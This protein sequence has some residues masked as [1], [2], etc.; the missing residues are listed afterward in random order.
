MAIHEIFIISSQL[1][2][3]FLVSQNIVRQPMDVDGRPIDGRSMAR[4]INRQVAALFQIENGHENATRLCA[5]QKKTKRAAMREGADTRR[6][7]EEALLSG[8]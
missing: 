8:H 3:C 4:P 6:C 5:L 7:N 2:T 1:S